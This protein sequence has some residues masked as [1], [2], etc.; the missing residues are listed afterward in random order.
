[1]KEAHQI[2][3]ASDYKVI[4]SQ[5][6][7][8]RDTL[9]RV[10]KVYTIKLFWVIYGTYGWVFWFLSF[11][12]YFSLNLPPVE[13]LHLTQQPGPL[14]L[15]CERISS[16]KQPVKCIYIY[17]SV[18]PKSSLAGINFVENLASIFRQKNCDKFGFLVRIVPLY[19]FDALGLHLLLTPLQRIEISPF[20]LEITFL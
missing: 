3:V 14:S 5:M 1:M 4:R 20:S 10:E 12:S 7:A 8:K 11:T 19:G 15:K 18:P 17:V 16:V 2:L 6:C 13:L 9:P